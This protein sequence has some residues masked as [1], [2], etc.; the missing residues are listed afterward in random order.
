LAQLKAAGCVQVALNT[1]H[2][3]DR[4]RRF[5]EENGPWGFDFQISHEPELLGTGGGLRN[6]GKLLGEG[7]FLAVNVDVLTDL[8]PAAIY[9]SHRPD[10]LASLVLH[11]CPPYNNVWVDR[12]GMVAGIGGPPSRGAATPLAYTGIQVVSPKMLAWLPP[13]GPYDLVQAWR[14]VIAGGERLATLL[15]AGHFWQ[16]L[17]TPAAYLAAHQRL[18]RGEA[19]G[20]ARFFPPLADPL[21]GTGAVLEEG[22]ACEGGVCLGAAVRVGAGA[23]LKNT[24]A[25]DRAWIAPG[26]KL[27]ECIIGPGTHVTHSGQGAVVV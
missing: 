12:E 14:K 7:P 9:R 2:L 4:V 27:E 21:V 10:A 26:V 18:L 6:L 24:V 20:L 16:D 11:D 22:V 17:G 19:P 1:H 23:R 5:L 13:S 8:D 25:W 3:A 15:V